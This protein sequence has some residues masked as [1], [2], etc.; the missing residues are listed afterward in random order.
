MSWRTSGVSMKIARTFTIDYSLAREL[1]NKP[2]Q[3]N[4][5]C[6][7]LRAWLYPDTF[8]SIHSIQSRQLM[9]ALLARDELSEG[10]KVMLL[11]ELTLSSSEEPGS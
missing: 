5:V 6:K 7:A 1:Q 8:N 4:T 11:H 10:L 9:A 2:N 3:S